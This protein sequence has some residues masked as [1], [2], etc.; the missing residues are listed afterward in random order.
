MSF[1]DNFM[2]KDSNFKI[3]ENESIQSIEEE[4][5][6]VNFLCEQL[7]SYIK[8]KN[9]DLGQENKQRSISSNVRKKPNELIYPNRSR[10]DVITTP[11]SDRI[12]QNPMNKDHSVDHKNKVFERL[13]KEKENKIKLNEKIQQ[14]Q[15]QEQEKNKNRLNK[16]EVNSMLSR[17]KY[18]QIEKQ[19]KISE[20]KRKVIN[21]EEQNIKSVPEI[22]LNSKKLQNNNEDDFLTRMEKLREQ[23]ELKKKEMIDKEQQR[24]NEEEMQIIQEARSR[25]KKRK[26][27][28]YIDQ[29]NKSNYKESEF[30]EDF[31][32]MNYKLKESVFE[33]SRP[34]KSIE[35]DFMILRDDPI[36]KDLIRNRIRKSNKND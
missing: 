7:E 20:M 5:N 22:S 25:H 27:S 34:R 4:I 35:E 14:K 3:I 33:N 28:N 23:S 30:R 18:Y 26:E 31:N 8:G 12:V 10:A 6:R 24:K 15:E 9:S 32:N 17:F 36:I 21:K 19:S 16:N 13:Y 29:K 2:N 11:S 1:T